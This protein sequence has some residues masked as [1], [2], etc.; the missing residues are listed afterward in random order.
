MSKMLCI[1]KTGN[2]SNILTGDEV[3]DFVFKNFGEYI[4]CAKEK[5]C[6]E[7]FEEQNIR[8]IAESLYISLATPNGVEN[9]LR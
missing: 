8:K 3:R 5:L 6:F 7:L 4:K 1:P 2:Y 9:M